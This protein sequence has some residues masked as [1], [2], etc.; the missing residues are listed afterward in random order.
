MLHQIIVNLFR[1]ATREGVALG[2][3]DI[4]TVVH[5]EQQHQQ[6]RLQSEPAVALLEQYDFEEPTVELL[7]SK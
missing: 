5:Q 6:E 4:G 7:E 3:Q 1:R 2:L